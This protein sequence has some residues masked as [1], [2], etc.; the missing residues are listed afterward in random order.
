MKNIM[1]NVFDFREFLLNLLKKGKFI[2]ILALVLGF[3]GAGYGYLKQGD[4]LSGDLS[5]TYTAT[6]TLAANLKDPGSAISVN[7]AL[8]TVTANLSTDYFYEGLLEEYRNDESGL[9][10]EL[11]PGKAE[12]TAGDVRNI[13]AITTKGSWLFFAVTTENEIVSAR[14]AEAGGKYVSTLMNDTLTNVTMDQMTRQSITANHHVAVS[15]MKVGIKFGLLG[16]AAGLGIG[17]LLLSFVSIFSLKVS[18]AKDLRR[19]DA[20]ILGEL[21]KPSRKQGGN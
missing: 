14:A 17:I 21:A 12:P 4:S 7:T 10:A 15:R 9:L 1:E 18:S 8:L 16:V 13:V 6:T 20:P 5:D 11:F 2:L 19:Y 3:I